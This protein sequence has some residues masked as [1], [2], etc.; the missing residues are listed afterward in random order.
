MLQFIRMS[1]REKITNSTKRSFSC[2]VWVIKLFLRIHAPYTYMAIFSN[3]G[4]E[5]VQIVNTFIL[6]KGIDILL[7]VSRQE[8]SIQS[9]YLVVFA[10]FLIS[11]IQVALGMASNYS[12]RLLSSMYYPKFQE[13]LYKKLIKLG[14]NTLEDPSLNNLI[15][16]SRRESGRIERLFAEVVVVLGI[17]T[18]VITSGAIILKFA[19][20]L[21]PIFIVALIPTALIDKKYMSKIWRFNRTQTEERRR[22]YDSAY[23]LVDSKFLH[24]LRITSGYKFLQKHF[25]EFSNNWIGGLVRIRSKWYKQ[26]FFLRIIRAL[27][28]A[29]ADL[30]IFLQF[31]NSRITIGNVTFYIRQVSNFTGNLTSLANSINIINESSLTI[32]ETRHLFEIDEEKDGEIELGELKSGPEIEFQDISFAYPK[33]SR[34]V[35]KNLSLKIRAGEKVAIVGPNGAGKTTLIKLLLRFYNLEKGKILINGQDLKDLKI[36]DFYTNVGVMFQDFNAY[37]NLTLKQNITIGK[38]DGKY[39]QDE[40]L[41]GSKFANVDDFVVEYKDGYDQLLSEKFKGGTRPSTGQWQKIAI[42]RFFYRNSPLVI[43][44]EPTAAIDAES[45]AEIFDKI[46]TF[47]NKKTVIIISHRFSTVRNADRI[48]VLDKGNIIEEGSHEVLMK[49]KGKYS[50]L[51]ELQAKGYRK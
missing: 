25:E 23:Y 21:L 13:L 28:E 33:N 7:A 24:E 17:I 27:V 37:P 14:I 4:M 38:A 2:S 3:I 50:R 26:I 49:K 39:S 1:I 6:A 12:Q 32:E 5:I 15:E 48:I 42:A 40:M 10:F 31:I 35:I 45:E 43:F 46:Y 8:Q 30:Y 51:F 20:H 34:K 36:R 18:S 22:A 29:Y 16:R 44:D 19:P 47:F 11:L 9:V 41:R